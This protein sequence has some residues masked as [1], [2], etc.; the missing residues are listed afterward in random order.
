V[1]FCF[2]A[3]R[4][5]SELNPAAG[6]AENWHLEVIAA[7]LTAVQEGKIRRLIINLPPRSVT[8]PRRRSSASAMRRNSPTSS[9]GIAAA[10]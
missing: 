5:F 4:C 3:Q 6:F 2:F 10:S 8:T 9:L 1:A 7:K